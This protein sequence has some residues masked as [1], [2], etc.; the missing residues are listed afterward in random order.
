MRILLMLT[1]AVMLSGCAHFFH[2]GADQSCEA[3]SH[4]LRVHDSRI[5][6]AR[7]SGAMGFT[8]TLASRGYGT[9]HCITRAGN[10]IACTE[11]ARG[12]AQYQTV[13]MQRLMR[14]RSIIEHRAAHACQI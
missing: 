7:A 11:V 12:Y 5:E 8:A 14:E 2:R 10:Q 6:A 3:A 9:Y 4:A 13:Q 1:S